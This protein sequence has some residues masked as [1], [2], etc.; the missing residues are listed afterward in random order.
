LAKEFLRLGHQ[1]RKPKHFTTATS[2]DLQVTAIVIKRVAEL[3]EKT[4]RAG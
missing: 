2:R 4:S 1:K 3:M